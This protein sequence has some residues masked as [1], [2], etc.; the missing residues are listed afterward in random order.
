MEQI[1]KALKD[2]DAN[3]LG[4]LLD[5]SQSATLEDYQKLLQTSLSTASG[6]GK[7]QD[8]PR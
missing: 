5:A 2:E 1:I 3:V 4:T 7:L 8:P 6:L